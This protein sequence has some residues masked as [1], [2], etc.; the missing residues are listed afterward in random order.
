[1]DKNVSKLGPSVCSVE[2][3][4][5]TTLKIF[6]K[7]DFVVVKKY[8][9]SEIKSIFSQIIDEPVYFLIKYND[10]K[11]FEILNSLGYGKH[12]LFINLKDLNNLN[13]NNLQCLYITRYKK[14]RRFKKIFKILCNIANTN[15]VLL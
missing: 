12:V 15:S 11:T 14:A 3:F 10:F 7:I 8:E 1:M 4:T 2:K 13:K 5:E 6:I 9:F